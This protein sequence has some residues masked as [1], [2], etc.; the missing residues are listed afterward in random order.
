MKNSRGVSVNNSYIIYVMY[1]FICVR[2]KIV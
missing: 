1:V 2:V